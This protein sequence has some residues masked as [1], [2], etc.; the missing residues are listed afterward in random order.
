MNKPDEYEK[1][2]RAH[3]AAGLH[4]MQ[5]SPRADELIACLEGEIAKRDARIA[6]MQ[7]R[8]DS[9]AHRTSLIGR[10]EIENSSLR[11]ELAAIRAQEPVAWVGAIEDGVP[12][13]VVEPKNWKATPLY[14]APASEAKAQGV[15]STDPLACSGCASGCFRCASP[16]DH[17]EDVRAMVAKPS[18]GGVDG[19][20]VIGYKFTRTFNGE[21]FLSKDG[22]M[23]AHHTSEPLCRLS[24]AQAIIDGLGVENHQ[25]R[26]ELNLRQ[27]QID[28]SGRMAEKAQRVAVQLRTERDQQAQRIGE[29]E[30]LLRRAL[31]F[32]ISRELFDDIDVALYAGHEPE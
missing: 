2:E 24:D 26:R 9:S 13:L 17:V 22:G 19:L 7:E 18:P 1:L 15:Y 31:R 6:E 20:G 5:T 32:A 16:A 8:F 10:L 14:A 21:T 25:L 3:A 27:S 29:L 12:L 11:A 30:G 28:S 23:F 4:M